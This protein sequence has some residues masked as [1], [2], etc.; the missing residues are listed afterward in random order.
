ME[1][2]GVEITKLV[3]NIIAELMYAKCDVHGNEYLFVEVFSIVEI[4]IQLSVS[5][6]RK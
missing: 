6:I 5:R 2:P 4:M 3:A 1:F